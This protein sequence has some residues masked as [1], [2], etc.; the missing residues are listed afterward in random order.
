MKK[1]L[2]ISLFIFLILNNYIQSQNIFK[3]I[4]KDSITHEALIGVAASI[5]NTSIGASSDANGLI[6]INNITDGKHKIV[7]Y[8]VGYKKTTQSFD[9]PIVSANPIIVN[10]SSEQTQIEEVVVSSTRTNSHIDDLPTKVEVLGQEDMD[11]E[12]TIVPGNISS[13]LGDLSII[14]IQRTNPVNGN[15]AIRM[16]GLDSKYT[17]IM[18]DGLPLYGGFSGSLGVLAIPPLDLKQVEII[19]GS[20]S[21][22]YGGGAIGG[23]INF[24]SKTPTDST[25]ATITLN[26]TSLGEG[27]VNAFVSGKKNKIGATLFTGVNVKQAVDVNNDGFAEV[28]ADQNYII[29]PKLFFDISPKTQVIVGLSSNYDARMGGDITAIK[30]G[31]DSVHS[32]LETEKTFRN[33]LD[34]TLTK[35]FLKHTLTIKTAGSAFQRDVNYSGFVFNGTDYSTYSEVN[36]VVKFNKHTIVG[37]LNFISETFV[38]GKNDAPLFKNYNY[39]TVGSFLQ[40]DWQALEKLSFQLGVRYDYHNVFGAFF[41]P[42]VSLFYKPSSKFT[43]RLAAGSGYKTPNMFDLMEPSAYMNNIPGNLK[44]ENSY[45]VNADI[46][47]H[48]L[49]FDVLSMQINQAFYYTNIQHPIV[50]DTVMQ[51]NLVAGNGNYQVNSY[52][53]D[54][55]I[56]LGFHDVELY[57]GYN[58]TESVQQH[59]SIKYN[60][61]FNPKDKFSATLAYD[62][63][64]QWRMGIETAYAANQYIYNNQSVPNYWF[65]ATMVERKFKKMSIVL[66]CENLL[67]A[68]QSKFGAIVEGTRENPLF[69]P[70][71]GP[72]EGRIINLSVKIK[73]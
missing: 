45:G 73:I 8:F 60:M 24:I 38:L 68:R 7:F 65:M 64:G 51:N 1:K 14:T 10:L 2:A 29:H 67:D 35:Q 33:T 52:G 32:F 47:Y 53:T 9:F 50:L 28:P 27:N 49:L 17:Q 31:A 39:N 16:Q 69:K 54:T 18:R 3:A 15:D 58:H 5:E 19:K 59:T 72:V 23:L 71:W 61:P 12:S 13:I 26:G 43:I 42:R 40:D 62:I 11:E 6:T 4:V 55:Y 36:D 22:L 46:N 57:L 63:E 25:Q 56:R 70:L 48:T 41:L 34:L 66:N 37:G 21:T 44:S 30:N 20:A